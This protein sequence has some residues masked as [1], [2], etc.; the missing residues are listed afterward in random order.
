VYDSQ[1]LF[2]TMNIHWTRFQKQKCGIQ[3]N[4]GYH[5]SM[6]TRRENEAHRVGGYQQLTKPGTQC[7]AAS[8]ET[9]C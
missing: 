9:A 1:N 3:D 5:S 8:I 7:K 4:K 6:H 2:V